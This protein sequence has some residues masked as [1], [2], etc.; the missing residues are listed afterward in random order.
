MA[1]K[2][3]LCLREEFLLLIMNCQMQDADA[4][5]LKKQLEILT[6]ELTRAYKF[7]P[8]TS[9]EAN[10]ITGKRLSGG[11][12]TFSER[13]QQLPTGRSAQKDQPERG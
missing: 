1:A 12:M 4:G 10:G 3:V 5:V 2:E 9:P 11:E 7:M 8:D 13:N 6:R